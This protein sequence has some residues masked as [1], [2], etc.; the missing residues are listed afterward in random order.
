M[1]RGTG[2]IVALLALAAGLAAILAL[3]LGGSSGG[4]TTASEPSVG[5]GFAGAALPP[6]APVHDFT[7]RDQLGRRVS[8]A[9]ERGKVVVLSF[10]YSG[11]G[12][13]CVVIAQQIRGALDELAHPVPVLI[14][15]A[16]P[17]GD[18]P[19]KIARFLADVSLSGRVSYLDGP[20]A[21]LRSL[22]REYR[23][24]PAAAGRRAFDL[25]ASVMLLDRHGSERV[26]FQQEQLTP[27]SLTHDI[28]K[29][30]GG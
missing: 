10:L 22:W 26:L 30:E 15:S 9:D 13:S 25:H 1:R 12:A 6:S 24:T 16:D 28:R 8:L 20:V 14:V 21:Q 23:V 29:L 2:T 11:C 7:L 18:T 27:E 17:R 5:A 19:A 4:P 3:A